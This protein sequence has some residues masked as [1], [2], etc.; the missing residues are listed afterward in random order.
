MPKSPKKKYKLRPTAVGIHIYAGG[1]T[2]GVKQAGFDVLCHLEIGKYGV[3]SVKANWPALPVHIGEENWPLK[4]LAK[5]EV[6]LL[7]SNPPCAIF[8]VAGIST[9]QGPEAWR[10]DPRLKDW[11]QA[12]QVF[13]QL[14]PKVF[15]L[16]SVCQAYSKGRE[17]IDKFTSQAISLGYSVQHVLMDA[18]W[19]GIPQSRKRFFFVAYRP[20]LPLE[21][22]FDWAKPPTVGQVLDTIS[23][24]GH[25]NRHNRGANFAQWIKK[26]L[27]GGSLVHTF[28]K[29]CPDCRGKGS[30][31]PGFMY[32]RLR[33]NHQMGV[34]TGDV[35]SHPTKHRFLGISEMKV[36][37]GYPLDFRLGG[38]PSQHPSLL[39]R[40]VLPPVGEWLADS[41]LGMITMQARR[42]AFPTVTLVDIRKPP[43]IYY[44]LTAEYLSDQAKAKFCKVAVLSSQIKSCDACPRMRGR[45]RVLGQTSGN[46]DASILFVGEAPGR[47]GAGQTGLPFYGDESGARFGML[48]DSIGLSYNDIFIANAVLCNP[49][50]DGGKNATPTQQEVKNC[51]NWLYRVIKLVNPQ[52]IATSG[53]TALNAVKLIESHELRLSAPV[54]KPAR[55]LSRTLFPL[56]HTSPRVLSTRSFIK[57]KKD[58]RLLKK[59]VRPKIVKPVTAGKAFQSSKKPQLLLT[60]STPIQVGS[61]RTSLKIVTAAAAWYRAFTSMGYDV[62]WRSILPGENL[63]KY[64]VIC[65]ILNQPCSISSIHVWGAVWAMATRR[66]SVIFLDDWQT[67]QLTSRFETCARSHERAFRLLKYRGPKNEVLRY[68]R[69]LLATVSNLAGGKW[70]WPVVVPILGDGDVSLLGLPTKVLPIDPTFYT[71]RYPK[72]RQARQKNYEWIMASLLY[73]PTPQLSWPI[74]AYGS[75]DRTSGMGGIGSPGEKAQPRVPEAELMKVY[76]SAWGV[77]SPAHPHAGSGWWRVRYLMSADAGCVLSADLQ[78]AA[79]L[80][81]AYTR[82]SD[83]GCVESLSDAGLRKLV[84]DQRKTLERITWPKE[85][86]LDALSSVLHSVSKLRE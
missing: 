83:T 47:K 85:R 63:D 71:K 19:T 39:A 9:T 64:K 80:G 18:K 28:D 29:F 72:P 70:L 35:F 10:D 45:I 12:W 8:S 78:E 51:S 22:R 11:Y 54:A 13:E 59:L 4:D 42:R 82:A 75:L 1:F 37:C 21:L 52:V 69:E 6:D 23:N 26:T 73:K 67:K 20:W 46:L 41:L 5:K 76:A 79:C 33:R 84:V 17:V 32:Y 14:R 57:Q 58:F 62:D 56:Y 44:D 60:G 7:Y 48:I 43:G 66:D 49:L 50:S 55:W 31:R 25:I 53:S 15:A 65:V 2:V 27:P 24:P 40:A 36:L 38:L 68:S 16:E 30:G 61:Q 77:L 81:K 74:K 86:V 34:F 3:A